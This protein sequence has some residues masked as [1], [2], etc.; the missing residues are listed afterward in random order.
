MMK[1][2]LHGVSSGILTTK[3]TDE[4]DA[5]QAVLQGKY[6]TGMETFDWMGERY[7]YEMITTKNKIGYI[8]RRYDE[9]KVPHFK[10]IVA[11]VKSVRIGVR[12]TKVYTKEFYPLDFEEIKAIQK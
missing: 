1:H 5:A 12:S 2:R 6:E 8:D 7:R 3:E 4:Q 10:L 11:K 9:N